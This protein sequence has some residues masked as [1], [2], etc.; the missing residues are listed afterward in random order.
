MIKNPPASAGDTGSIPDPGRCHMPWNNRAQ[1]P[2]LLSLC[3]LE[4]VL[5]EATREAAETRKSPH[6]ATKTLCSQN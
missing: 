5:G 3:T 1:T 4:P 2:Q 6:T